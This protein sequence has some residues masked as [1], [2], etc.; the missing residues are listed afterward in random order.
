MRLITAAVIGAQLAARYP[1]HTAEGGVVDTLAASGE[2]AKTDGETV[3]T[4][5]AQAIRSYIQPSGSFVYVRALTPHLV[6]GQYVDEGDIVQVTDTDAKLLA[7]MG[8]A[9][10]ATDE[11]VAAAS[12]KGSKGK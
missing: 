3:E 8:R 2:T 4:I 1:A 7:T 9:V 10:E 11:E 5:Q 12:S 6:A